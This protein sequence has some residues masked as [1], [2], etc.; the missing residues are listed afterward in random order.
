M[1]QREHLCCFLELLPPVQEGAGRL[2][3][4]GAGQ[5]T[6]ALCFHA[7]NHAQRA[8]GEAQDQS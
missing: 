3:G 1:E 4:V 8:M 6:D 2:P 5:M 7:L